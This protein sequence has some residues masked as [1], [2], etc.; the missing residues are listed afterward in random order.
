MGDAVP[1]RPRLAL[2]RRHISILPEANFGREKQSRL[3][4]GQPQ[5]RDALMT[6]PRLT[7]SGSVE[8]LHG[9]LDGPPDN[10]PCKACP[11]AATKLDASG[12][13]IKSC[14]DAG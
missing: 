8:A 11:R 4:R 6:H 9:S 14:A 5:A 12:P 3:A 1:S 10:F 7:S 2:G 13:T